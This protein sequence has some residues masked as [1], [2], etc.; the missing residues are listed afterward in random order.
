M[1]RLKTNKYNSVWTKC[2]QGHK[3]QSKKESAYCNTLEL[4]RKDGKIKGYDTQVKFDLYCNDVYTCAHIVDF[5]IR[6]NNGNDEVHEV[7]SKAT[8]TAVWKIKKKLFELNYP[9]I[10][11]IVIDKIRD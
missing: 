3:H 8:M 11:Y 9:D 2:N 4:L 1:I 6:D 7:K 5:L 10:K